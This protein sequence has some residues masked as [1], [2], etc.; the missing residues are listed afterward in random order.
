MKLILNIHTG[1]QSVATGKFLFLYYNALQF[2][3][4]V[5]TLALASI[6]NNHK[7]SI[8]PIKSFPSFCHICI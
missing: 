6:Y 1:V 4:N 5:V 3:N 7:W 8:K 2:N